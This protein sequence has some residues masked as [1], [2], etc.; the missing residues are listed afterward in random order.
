MYAYSNYLDE[1]ERRTHVLDRLRLPFK[2]KEEHG[3]L[4]LKLPSDFPWC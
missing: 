4:V 2:V 3:E 1:K